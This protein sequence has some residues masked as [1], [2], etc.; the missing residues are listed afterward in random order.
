MIDPVAPR[1]TAIEAK[2]VVT[3]TVVN[4]SSV[5]TEMRDLHPKNSEIGQAQ[6]VLSPTILMEQLDCQV[7][8]DVLKRD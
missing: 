7:G 4:Q 2:N 3:V 1:H 8:T 5:V 6:L